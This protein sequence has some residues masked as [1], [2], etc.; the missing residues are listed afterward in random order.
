MIKAF[1]SESD[2]P[3]NRVDFQFNP[4]SIKVSKQANFQAQQNQ[5]AATSPAQQFNGAGAMTLSLTLL[6]DSV[7][8]PS[9]DVATSVNQLLTWTQPT[10][11]SI[12]NKSPSPPQLVF[13]WGGLRIGPNGLFVGHLTSAN[14]T[15][16]LFTSDGE[17]VRAEVDLS[18]QDGASTPA[19]TNPSSG[20]LQTRRHHRVVLGET[21]HSIAFA[22]YGDASLW[23]G[24]ATSNSIDDPLR[25]RSGTDLLLPELAE[26]RREALARAE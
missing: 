10:T 12:A 3:G 19:P 9:P 21:L 5:T 6:L 13:T 18:L 20:G 26:L 24:I 16:T 11:D 8:N 7:G 22:E 17:P 23:R 14:V 25:I 15:Y 1:L 2:N 4:T